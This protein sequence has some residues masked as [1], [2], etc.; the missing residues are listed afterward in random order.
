MCVK[1]GLGQDCVQ[2]GASGFDTGN[3]EKLSSTQATRCI[4]IS[5]V[6]EFFRC[7]VLTSDLDLTVLPD[8]EDSS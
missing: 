8:L 6:V 1:V 5:R 4:L 3:R 2:S 7:L